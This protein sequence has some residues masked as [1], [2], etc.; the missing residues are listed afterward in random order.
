M[1]HAHW[2]ESEV[3]GFVSSLLTH[4]VA[5]P[6]VTVS[7][8]RPDVPVAIDQCFHHTFL[9]VNVFLPIVRLNL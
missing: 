1:I 9:S 4:P 5:V 3:A 8:V 6:A 2:A 7:L